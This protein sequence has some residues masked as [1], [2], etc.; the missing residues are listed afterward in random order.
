MWWLLLKSFSITLQISPRVFQRFINFQFAIIVFKQMFFHLRKYE[1]HFFS[2]SFFFRRYLG[3][4]QSKAG[5]FKTKK[6][7]WLYWFLCSI[8]NIAFYVKNSVVKCHQCFLFHCTAEYPHQLSFAVNLQNFQ[9]QF[10]IEQL[11]WLLLRIFINCLQTISKDFKNAYKC[12][13]CYHCFKANVCPFT[14][15]ISYTTFVTSSTFEGVKHG[16]RVKL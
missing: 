14:K 4:H 2:V 9:G 11:R 10:F 8:N 5:I 7:K 13:V 1:S 12:W 3:R 15:K 6:T 16:I